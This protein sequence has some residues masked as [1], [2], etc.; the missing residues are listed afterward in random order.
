MPYNYSK[1]RGKI[2]EVYGSET[3]FAA[4][5]GD[6]MARPTLSLK[7]NGKSA[8]SQVEMQKVLDLLGEPFSKAGI[9]F[10]SK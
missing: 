6:C 1:L 5:M 10:F 7:L 4:A 2:K 3:K 8:W 9:Y